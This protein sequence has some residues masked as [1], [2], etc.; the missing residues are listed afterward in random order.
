M[1]LLNM[2]TFVHKIQTTFLTFLLLVSYIQYYFTAALSNVV[3]L[4]QLCSEKFLYRMAWRNMTACA[5]CL[6]IVD[7]YYHTR[8]LWLHVL[9]VCM[10]WID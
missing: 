3:D 5:E 1:N 6:D 9:R 2:C 4:V 8:M 10:L 7:V